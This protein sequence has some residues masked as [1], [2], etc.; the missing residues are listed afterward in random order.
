MIYFDE[1]SHVYTDASGQ[2]VYSVTQILEPLYDF[3]KISKEALDNASERGTIV[4]KACEML[5]LGTLDEQSLDE[6]IQQYLSGY[7]KFLS[8][9]GF[10]V[11]RIEQVVF[12]ETMGYCGTLDRTGKLG[13]SNVLVD[14][15]SGMKSP[16]TGPQTAAYSEALTSMVGG[17]ISKRFGLYIKPNDYKLIPYTETNDWRVFRACLDVHN[18]RKNND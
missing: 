4:H 2:R 15:K 18:W 7:K 1:D 8:E 10:R 16:V 17:T 14:I 9:S 12:N 13:R 6:E 3:S 11:D 5:D